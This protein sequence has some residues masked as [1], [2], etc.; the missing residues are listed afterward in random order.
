M[1]STR[2]TLSLSIIIAGALLLGR[3]SGLAANEELAAKAR[4]ILKANCLECHG[5][6]FTKAGITNILDRNLLVSK[7]KVVPSSPDDSLLYQVITAKDSSVMP[8]AGR[9]RLSPEQV[10][11]IKAW[12]ASGAPEF[13]AGEVAEE[14]ARGFGAESVLRSILQDIRKI[15]VAERKFMRVLQHRAPDERR[16]QQGGAGNP[17]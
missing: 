12:I 13:P 4:D 11:V 8:P 6:K 7:D 15:P 2:F 9:T 1:H 10:A 5:D 3:P 16:R 17:A 14:I